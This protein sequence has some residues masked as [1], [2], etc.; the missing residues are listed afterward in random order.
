MVKAIKSWK[1]TI[2]DWKWHAKTE[3][4]NGLYYGYIEGSE[5]EWGYFREDELKTARVVEID[6]EKLP[7]K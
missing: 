3:E 6:P 2:I 1:S 4:G 7:T 5:N